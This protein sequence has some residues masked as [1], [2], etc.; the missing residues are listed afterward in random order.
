MIFLFNIALTVV[1]LAA[2]SYASPQDNWVFPAN[3]DQTS[4]LIS[5]N[6]YILKWNSNLKDWFG[7]YCEACDTKNVDLWVLG[8]NNFHT[9][10]SGV[11]VENT[12]SYTWDVDIPSSEL[13][14]DLWVF[15][16]LSAGADFKGA[17]TQNIASPIIFIRE[18]GGDLGTTVG[19][20]T[21]TKA[22]DQSTE[23]PAPTKVEET[24]K[25]NVVEVT[26]TKEEETS[27]SVNTDAATE[28]PIL[29]TSAP[30]TKADIST[31]IKAT[32]AQT[33]TNTAIKPT[34][35]SSSTTA[36]PKTLL[37]T[38]SSSLPSSTSPAVDP[39]NTDSESLLPHGTASLNSKESPSSSA[40]STGAMVGIGVGVAISAALVCLLWFFCAQR[41]KHRRNNPQRG[42]SPSTLKAGHSSHDT[43][44]RSSKGVQ[45]FGS[46]ATIGM[47]QTR[48]GVS[49]FGAP[50]Y[51]V[52]IGPG[53]TGY[54]QDAGVVY[55]TAQTQNMQP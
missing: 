55:E 44:P 8:G 4:S 16:F 25:T 35:I 31:T 11:N 51:N 24:T 30:E 50:D 32:E 38:T 3:P 28:N 6:K 27:T 21:T 19:Q 2:P 29:T 46:T 34:K 33:S 40:L 49:G 17:E 52:A 23:Q 54:R 53:S 12:L 47:A 20:T 26:N 36:L 43:E 37:V 5:R 10:S 42:L 13:N 41:R 9:L 1:L 45:K 14:V 22:A 15:R 48:D 7:E 39:I 18:G